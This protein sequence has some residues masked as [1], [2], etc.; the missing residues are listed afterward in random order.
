MRVLPSA[1]V[2]LLAS[3]EGRIR[4]TIRWASLVSICR[5]SMVRARRLSSVYSSRSSENTTTKVL[6]P[7]TAAARSMAQRLECGRRGN[8]CLT[9][10]Y[11]CFSPC[12]EGRT[13]EWSKYR[14]YYRAFGLLHLPSSKKSALYTTAWVQKWPVLRMGARFL[15]SLHPYVSASILGPFDYSRDR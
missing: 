12:T 10:C 4:R 13:A 5:F 9:R 1:C 6:L 8:A 3:T 7:G 15:V 14:S 2:G 11:V